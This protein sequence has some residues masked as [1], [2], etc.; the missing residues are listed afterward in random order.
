VALVAAA[1]GTGKA[2]FSV[3]GIFEETEPSMH[4]CMPKGAASGKPEFTVAG[5]ASLIANGAI[6]VAC[7]DAA[8]PFF[9]GQETTPPQPTEKT[10]G[11]RVV[12]K[13]SLP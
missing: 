10:V 3:G 9:R 4:C 12:A 8:D 13:W 2:N 7:S 6:V 11:E 1:L 5:V